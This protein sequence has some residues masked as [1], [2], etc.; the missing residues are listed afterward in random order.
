MA[1]DLFPLHALREYVRLLLEP[2]IDRLALPLLKLEE[3]DLLLQ[4]LVLLLT[5]QV[6]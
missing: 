5:L 1:T 4:V 3:G 6:L 2:L